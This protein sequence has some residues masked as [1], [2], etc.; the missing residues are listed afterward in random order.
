MRMLSTNTTFAW[1][2]HRENE[3][4][5]FFAE[6][7]FLVCCVDEQDLIRKLG[8][9][10]ISNDWRLFID[11]SKSRLKAVL[12]HNTNQLLLFLCSLDLPERVL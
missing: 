6:E 9:V 12:L 10:Y 11:S 7:H 8:T 2:I 5:C 4:N 1:Y 3:Y